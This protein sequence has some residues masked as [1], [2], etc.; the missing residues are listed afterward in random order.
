MQSAP[1]KMKLKQEPFKKDRAWFVTFE[2]GQA[3]WFPFS[4]ISQ[5]NPGQLTIHIESWILT[6]KDIKFKF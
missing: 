1:V 2:N 6:Q 5:Y 3:D 4:T